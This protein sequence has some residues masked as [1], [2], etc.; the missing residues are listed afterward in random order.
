MRAA[1][2]NACARIAFGREDSIACNQS[3]PPRSLTC[4]QQ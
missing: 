2:N 1:I 4:G 3:T